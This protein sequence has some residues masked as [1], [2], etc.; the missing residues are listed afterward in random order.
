MHFLSNL[1]DTVGKTVKYVFDIDDEEILVFYYT[2]D[3]VL[4]IY[5][6]THYRLGTNAPIIAS[7]IVHHEF[8]RIK[9]IIE[10]ELIKREKTTK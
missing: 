9:R 1:Q 5:A 4:F 3:T 10:R 2:D 6:D 8:E 7:P